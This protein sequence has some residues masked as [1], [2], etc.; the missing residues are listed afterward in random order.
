MISFA[1]GMERLPQALAASLAARRQLRLGEAATALRRAP[2]GW[3][4]H[5]AGGWLACRHLVVATAANAA[6]PLLAGVPELGPP[7][8]ASL[9]EALLA[10]VVLGFTHT[11]R[12]PFG[13]GYL[14][15]EREGRF[16]L[17]TLFSSHM[18]PGRAPA[19]HQLLEAL[20]GGRRHPE[21][22]E[23]DDEQLVA[24]TYADLRQL[25]PLPD[26]PCFARVLRLQSGIP[27]LEAGY[28]DLLAWRARVE[29]A[30]PHLH[31]C[32]FGWTGIGIND[33]SKEAARVAAR[34][35]ASLH[36]SRDADADGARPTEVR[37]IYV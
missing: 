18:F 11:A 30:D 10:T 23:L 19:G 26:P 37:G 12:V 15:P 35:A 20:V 24:R 1:R 13:F 14:A 29:A 36:G 32:G 8:L 6:L 2:G 4:V 22:L 28:S 9:P 17:G 31:I 16:A 21:R 33:M 3:E 7:P 34:V 27:Q 5:S 25:L